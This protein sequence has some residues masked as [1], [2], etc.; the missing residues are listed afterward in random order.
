[1]LMIGVPTRPVCN[2]RLICILLSRNNVSQNNPLH[3]MCGYYNEFCT[4]CDI[5]N[6]GVPA[7]LQEVTSCIFSH[8]NVFIFFFVLF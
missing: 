8:C 3:W 4:N 5:F 1:M 7:L 2:Q 6:W